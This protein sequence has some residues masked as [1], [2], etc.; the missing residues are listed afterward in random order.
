MVAWRLKWLPTLPCLLDSLLSDLPTYL[1]VSFVFM[2]MFVFVFVCVYTISFR[3][4]SSSFLFLYVR[5][6]FCVACVRRSKKVVEGAGAIIS[7][8]E[9][10]GEGGAMYLLTYV[11]KLSYG[12][13]WFHFISLF[14]CVVV[15]ICS[16]LYDT[17]GHC[18]HREVPGGY[19]SRDITR[20][21]ATRGEGAEPWGKNVELIIVVAGETPPPRRR[22]TEMRPQVH[23]STQCEYLVKGW[24]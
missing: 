14:R 9:M 8:G 16:W 4:V 15:R 23:T 24:R 11:S 6:L 5:T 7:G 22:V 17:I 10:E 12:R 13:Q 1:V 2:F 18:A 21:L 3:I 19:V 20:S